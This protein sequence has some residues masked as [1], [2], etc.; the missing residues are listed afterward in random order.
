MRSRGIVAGNL[1]G[2]AVELFGVIFFW[3]VVGHIVI[4]F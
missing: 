1:C 3:L 2:I 4:G